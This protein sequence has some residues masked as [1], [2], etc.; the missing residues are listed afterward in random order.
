MELEKTKCVATWWEADPE[1]GEPETEGVEIYVSFDDD[2][3]YIDGL[4]DGLYL[5]LPL[6]AIAQAMAD[7]TRPAKG[8]AR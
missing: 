8:M 6:H 2:A 7:T 3:F 1:V 4:R 5:T